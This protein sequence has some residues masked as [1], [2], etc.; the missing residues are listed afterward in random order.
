MQFRINLKNLGDFWEKP[1]YAPVSNKDYLSGTNFPGTKM[2]TRNLEKQSI[3]IMF[4]LETQGLCLVIY[5]VI[6]PET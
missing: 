2:P 1:L 6:Y 3:I 5:C 4:T